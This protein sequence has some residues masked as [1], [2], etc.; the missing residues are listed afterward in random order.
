MVFVS[1]N[2][3]PNL[4]KDLGVDNKECLIVCREEIADELKESV[5][6]IDTIT[7]P[8]DRTL[9]AKVYLFFNEFECTVIIGSF[10]FTRNSMGSVEFYNIEK[11]NLYKEI[12]TRW[13]TQQ[14]E[15]E[16]ISDNYLVDHII[17]FINTLIVEKNNLTS[18][19]LT[20][21]DKYYDEKR[22]SFVNSI[23]NNSLQ[24][25][26][27][28]SLNKVK[29]KKN[30]ILWYISPFFNKTSFLVL[31][32]LLKNEGLNPSDFEI[33]IITNHWD[34]LS[35]DDDLSSY[36][37]PADIEDINA[38]FKC[39][40]LR[41]WCKDPKRQDLL[42]NQIPKRFLH[43][44]MIF[45][46]S[47]DGPE[48]TILTS[49]NFT[50]SV[51]SRN[52][53]DT[54]IEVGIYEPNHDVNILF[55]QTI[56][57]IWDI[58]NPF[59]NDLELDEFRTCYQ[60]ICE[61]QIIKELD[62]ESYIE[63][64]NFSEI[65]SEQW[66]QSLLLLKE[67]ELKL[68]KGHPQIDKI[69]ITLRLIHIDKT[70]LE[71]CS[72]TPS[73]PMNKINKSEYKLNLSLFSEFL[74]SKNVLVDAINYKVFSNTNETDISIDIDTSGMP[75]KLISKG[76]ELI[77]NLRWRA[78][79]KNTCLLLFDKD[80]KHAN[81][82]EGKI[83]YTGKLDDIRTIIL[84]EVVTKSRRIFESN[85]NLKN[86]FIAD[87]LF[88]NTAIEKID[89]PFGKLPSILLEYSNKIGNMLN[90]I[91]IHDPSENELEI[92]GYKLYNSNKVS[93]IVNKIRK[94]TEYK[95]L[96]LSPLKEV[97]K[98]TEIK[99]KS[100]KVKLEISSEIK[101]KIRKIKIPI[102][103]I[104]EPYKKY[105]IKSDESVEYP[106]GTKLIVDT[107]KPINDLRIGLL[108]VSRVIYQPFTPFDAMMG[109]TLINSYS[110]VSAQI[111]KYYQDHNIYFLLSTHNIKMSSEHVK[112]ININN[113]NLG[114]VYGNDG[115]VCVLYSGLDFY[116]RN[117]FDQDESIPEV[118]GKRKEKIYSLKTKFRINI[119]LMKKMIQT[120]DMI[121]LFPIFKEDS[122]LL[123][124]DTQQF[125]K[126]ARNLIDVQ[127]KKSGRIITMLANGEEVTTFRGYDFE[128]KSIMIKHHG[129]SRREN[130]IFFKQ[131]NSN[132]FYPYSLERL[133]RPKEIDAKNIS[134]KLVMFNRG[135]PL[136]WLV[137]KK[138]FL[139]TDDV[140]I[141]IVEFID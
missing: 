11:A 94:D 96:S 29:T 77:G 4:L 132:T 141:W 100:N 90:H 76:L 51:W 116:Y 92:V 74:S 113:I 67:L 112:K 126:K 122:F 115:P 23:G 58:K 1:Y 69:E 6:K 37:N 117:I 25:S 16:N 140:D 71:R 110:K 123:K 28:H 55:Q 14:Q 65:G 60:K 54:N 105:K 86:Y 41:F 66:T 45:I 81:I 91:R 85:I 78:S 42:G 133:E 130:S 87:N 33:R 62:F 109:I 80:I 59:V 36:I 47:E 108:E 12:N 79:K 10:N 7:L 50:R 34:F 22:T 134:Q 73:I 98:N 119:S 93:V 24:R 17:S 19:S 88:I 107:T 125:G 124:I 46:S 82:T 57:K 101:Q 95:I 64:S 139:R 103:L 84:R 21:S 102:Q 106:P 72:F 9:H 56:E 15:C 75:R 32:E 48:T 129:L 18:T 128:K 63:K 20:L 39:V 136:F 2:Y 52:I 61:N 26:L 27:A 111:F 13:F 120:G 138:L 8:K 35:I 40:K 118:I 31:C 99:F 104:P 44:K 70:G 97:F 89:T 38:L 127:I 131:P 5:P 3:T 43:G 30:P 68:K 53:P 137:K 114:H 83:E 135:E 121:F 49:G